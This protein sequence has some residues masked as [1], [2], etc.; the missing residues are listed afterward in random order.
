MV[1][2][3]IVTA[4]YNA[5]D[6]LTRC[7]ESVKTQSVMRESIEHIVVD[8]L[9][10]D[11]TLNI[12]DEH[13][14]WFDIVMCESDR[15]ISDAFNKGLHVASGEYIIF[16]S[17]DDYFADDSVLERFFDYSSSGADVYV[18]AVEKISTSGSSSL[19]CPPR[20]YGS[21]R[22]GMTVNHPG[23]FARTDVVKAVGGFSEEYNLAMDYK[24]C[25]LLYEAG[26]KYQSISFCSTIVS[27]AGISHVNYISSL[28]EVM[29]AQSDAGFGRLAVF[30]FYFA[31]TRYA[32][33]RIFEAIGLSYAVLLYRRYFSRN[34]KLDG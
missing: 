32:V 22:R 13:R 15:G 27:E 17:A 19:V 20:N 12:I 11:G 33:R 3:S 31:R 16:L 30:N 18:A 10:T 8:G 29:R 25:L 21:L 24:L 14:D 23:M 4:T 2:V 7:I 26:Y 6:T 34:I 28:R 1:K 5:K 9:S